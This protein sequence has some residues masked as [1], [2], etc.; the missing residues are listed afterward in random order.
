MYLFMLALT[1]AGL[2]FAFPHK[3]ERL[4]PFES[5]IR[6]VLRFCVFRRKLLR[7]HNVR[8]LRRFTRSRTRVQSCTTTSW[9]CSTSSRKHSTWRNSTRRSDIS[10]NSRC[11]RPTLISPSFIDSEPPVNDSREPRIPGAQ[12][13]PPA[14]ELRCTPLSRGLRLR[15]RR[16]T[17]VKRRY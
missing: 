9:R 10:R 12:S 7:A 3:Q 11:T 13:P 17:Y 8:L 6:Q 2:M 15:L 1:V 16:L 4:D 5:Y 14:T